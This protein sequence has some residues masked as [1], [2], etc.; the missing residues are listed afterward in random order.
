MNFIVKYECTDKNII[1]HQNC[2]YCYVN[3][4][5]N[6]KYVGQAKNFKKRHGEHLSPSGKYPQAIDKALEKYGKE[7]FYVVILRENLKSL[8]LINLLECYYIDKLNTMANNGCGYNIA[9]GGRN[10]NSYAGKSEEE[11]AIIKDKIRQKSLG[12]KHTTEVKEKL[13]ESALQRGSMPIEVRK[14][15]SESMKG[16]NN[17][18]YGKKHSEET[19]LK[20]KEANKTRT[21]DKN[22]NYGNRGSKNPLSKKTVCVHIS[23]GEIIIYDSQKVA[24]HELSKKHG[25]RY[26][27]PNIN[28]ICKC[29][30][31]KEAYLNKHGRLA[32][33]SKGYTFYDLSDYCLKF[34]VD[35][36]DMIRLYYQ[37]TDYANIA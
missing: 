26:N 3:K 5:N 1:N 10:G 31:D 27:A 12:R 2:I 30:S 28:A 18:F 33:S 6:K 36:E 32:L 23:T 21:G 25:I 9:T 37:E 17:P 15:I 29:N 24:S 11:M 35:E 19:I 14:K 7:N 34:N 16:E 13:R 4:V 20:I 22:S 8:C